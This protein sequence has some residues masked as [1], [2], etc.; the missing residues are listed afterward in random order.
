MA[1]LYRES[2]DTKSR[3]YRN[4]TTYS[5]T[6]RDELVIAAKTDVTDSNGSPHDGSGITLYGNADPKHPYGG[7]A[8]HTG[9]E[10]NLLVDKE[11][12]VAVGNGLFTIMD[13]D[14]ASTTQGFQGVL[15]VFGPNNRPEIYLEGGNATTEGDITWKKGE[16]L[17]LGT[18]DPETAAFTEKL[19]IKGNLDNYVLPRYHDMTFSSNT[20]GAQTVNITAAGFT[21]VFAISVEDDFNHKAPYN[22]SSTSFTID[23]FNV[24]ETV[25]QTIAIRILGMKEVDE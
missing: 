16:D 22:I 20:D 11:G 15:N 14:D 9:G 6:P 24:G 18:W 13:E 7:I 10:G 3:I 17:S 1:S 8:V 2:D 23:R 4:P 12:R 5:G 25:T 21:H 19:K